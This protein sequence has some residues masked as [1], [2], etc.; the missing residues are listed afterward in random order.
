[1]KEIDEDNEIEEL[2]FSRMNRI[3]ILELGKIKNK[4]DSQKRMLDFLVLEESKSILNEKGQIFTVYSGKK[5]RRTM[6]LG[7]CWGNS[8]KMMLKGYGYVEGYVIHKE[9]GLKVSH[10]WNV[11]S[12]GTHLD[13]TY[14]NPGDYEY[15]GIIIPNNIVLE[16]GRKNGGMW[17]CVL[18]FIDDFTLIPQEKSN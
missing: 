9:T 2:Y 16:V 10:S 17:F 13:F 5:D 3:Q 18:P 8:S 11:D 12:S 14:D 1:M 7:F 6:K 15:F 4:L